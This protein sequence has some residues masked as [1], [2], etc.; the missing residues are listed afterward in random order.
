MNKLLDEFDSIRNNYFEDERVK[1]NGY[2]NK[3]DEILGSSP[4]F[5]LYIGINQLRVEL[6]SGGTVKLYK[7]TNSVFINPKII[8]LKELYGEIEKWIDDVGKI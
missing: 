2:P 7:S 5:H 1:H 3:H 8:N 6:L 4:L